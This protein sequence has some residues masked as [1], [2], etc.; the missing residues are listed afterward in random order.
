MRCSLS[1]G[2]RSGHKLTSR[3]FLSYAL[4]PDHRYPQE[5]GSPTI[6]GYSAANVVQV[7]VNDLQ[8]VGRIIDNAKRA[9]ANTIQSLHFTLKDEQTLR[10]QALVEAATRARHKVEVIASALGLKIVRVLAV[11]ESGADWPISPRPLMEARV[12]M[13]LPPPVEPG[14]IEVTTQVTL[15]VEVAP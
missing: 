2:R 13:A 7:K 14:S 1:R 8:R 10:A 9:G 15:T 4:T 6:A 3:P 11:E 5:G 12:A